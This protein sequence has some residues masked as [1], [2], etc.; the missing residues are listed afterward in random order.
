MNQCNTS[1]NHLEQTL[2]LILI[3]VDAEILKRARIVAIKKGTSVNAVL[4]D[5]LAVYAG[6]HPAARARQEFVKL[7][8]RSNASS[9]EG[10]RTWTRDELYER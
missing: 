3:T 6:E 10:G 1:R 7:A 2:W 9:G 4:R 8:K 5:Y